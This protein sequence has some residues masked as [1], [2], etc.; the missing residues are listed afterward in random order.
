M[1]EENTS[2]Y[3]EEKDIF[4]FWMSLTSIHGL[5]FAY[6][7]T[8]IRRRIWLLLFFSSLG[9]SV[10]LVTMTV[11][12]YLSYKATS[13]LTHDFNVRKLD[14]P[15]V[16]ICNLNALSKKKIHKHNSSVVDMMRHR[17]LPLHDFNNLSH[18]E[19]I[20]EEKQYRNGNLSVA[21]T[22]RSYGFGIN[23]MLNDPKLK[24]S[25]PETCVFK[26]RNCKSK[27]FNSVLTDLGMCHV[28]NQK[29]RASASESLKVS[30]AGTRNGLL[31]YMMIHADDVLVG[32][33]LTGLKV[34]VHPIGTS[35]LDAINDGFALQ[36]GTFNTI[37]VRQKQ[38]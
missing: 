38:V 17:I 29:D 20:E 23:E 4:S 3:S 5:K 31:I 28:F 21:Q 6:G 10:L 12:E 27:E 13:A 36:P 14:F 16:T 24:A 33:P 34:H 22:L 7:T 9:L 30:M 18:S 15:T 19:N 32:N 37:T 26:K 35:S 11:N 1:A 25:F 8:G 2:T